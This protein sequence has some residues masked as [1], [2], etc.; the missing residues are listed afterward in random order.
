MGAQRSGRPMRRKRPGAAVAPKPGPR[1]DFG[2]RAPISSF[3]FT[4]GFPHSPLFFLDNLSFEK[5]QVV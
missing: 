3:Q 2:F 4:L 1:L 5:L